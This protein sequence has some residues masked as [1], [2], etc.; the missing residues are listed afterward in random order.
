MI[1]YLPIYNT[2]TVQI[3]KGKY[4]F[5][6]IKSGPLFGEHSLPGQMEEQLATVYIFH[7][8]AEPVVCLK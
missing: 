4:N 7:H 6:T 2:V 8:K 3:A 5:G 1:N